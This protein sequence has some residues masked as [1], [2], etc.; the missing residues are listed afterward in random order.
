MQV[1]R[2]GF[3][4][5]DPSRLNKHHAQLAKELYSVIGQSLYKYIGP[6]EYQL[7]EASRK[8]L[9]EARMGSST[10]PP[11]KKTKVERKAKEQAA[12]SFPVSLKDLKVKVWHNIHNNI[13]TNP[14]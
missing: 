13:R 14:I 10:E 7:Q 11:A 6:S 9:N 3:I 1:Y 2:N 8:I 4:L 5:D 12:P